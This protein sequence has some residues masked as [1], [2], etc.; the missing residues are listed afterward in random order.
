MEFD[1]R[2]YRVSNLEPCVANTAKHSDADF[3]PQA[4][5]TSDIQRKQCISDSVPCHV[6]FSKKYIEIALLHFQSWRHKVAGIET[7]R[8]VELGSQ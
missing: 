8:L 7:Q 5:F 2:K 3:A 6:V 1:V 4:E